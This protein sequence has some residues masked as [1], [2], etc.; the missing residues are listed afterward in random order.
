LRVDTFVKVSLYIYIF[1]VKTY[2][3]LCKFITLN[4]KSM[5]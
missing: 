5:C 1:E 2:K 4:V 3:I